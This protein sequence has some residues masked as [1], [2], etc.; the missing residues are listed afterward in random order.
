MKNLIIAFITF[1]IFFSP[2]LMARDV[3]FNV[4]VPSTTNQCLIVGNFIDW[5]IA[6]AKKCS[7]ID[8]THYRIILN[9]STWNDSVTIL[10]LKYVYLSQPCDWMYVE[11]AINGMYIGE[12]TYKE[13]V[14]DTV[15]KWSMGFYE[16]LPSRVMTPKGTKHCYLYGNVNGRNIPIGDYELDLISVNSDSTVV[17]SA[18]FADNF[19]TCDRTLSYR[20]S[21]GPSL[22]YDQLIPSENFYNVNMSIVIDAWKAIYTADPQLPACK[23]KIYN[24]A[25]DIIIEGTEINDVVTVYNVTGLKVRTFKSVGEPIVFAA[26]EH[27]IYFVKTPDKSAKILVK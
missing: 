7:K 11:R 4:V 17:F 21:S 2:D 22:D 12:R 5:K 19:V 9:D 18:F 24:N 23:V 26:R 16:N 13:G 6:D 10:N 25:S 14:N 20:F 8:Q 1:L 27:E 15:V 3:V